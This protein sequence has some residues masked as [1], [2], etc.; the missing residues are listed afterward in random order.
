MLLF[1]SVRHWIHY[2]NIGGF[3][4]E[5]LL[6]KTQRTTERYFGVKY[7]KTKFC[8]FTIMLI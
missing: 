7:S 3:R 2:C 6:Q 1:S 5:I 4:H 8:I